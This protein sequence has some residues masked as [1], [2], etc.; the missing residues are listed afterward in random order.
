LLLK[1]DND[2]G[3]PTMKNTTKVKYSERWANRTGETSSQNLSDKIAAFEEK[4]KAKS[5]KR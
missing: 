3:K 5:S 2:E 4:S 1:D